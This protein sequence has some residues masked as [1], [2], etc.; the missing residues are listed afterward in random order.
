MKRVSVGVIGCG[1]IAQMM[2][3]PHL[4][5]LTQLFEVNAVCDLNAPLAEAVAKRFEVPRWT[6]DYRTLLA[7]PIEAFL[8]LTSGSHA[9]ITL[10][11][12]RAGKHVFVEKPL[13]YTAS[14]GEALLRA[15][16]LPEQVM[17]GY[18]K[19]FDPSY[20]KAQQL[21]RN[22]GRAPLRAVDVLVLHPEES[23]YQEHHHL[24]ATPAAEVNDAQARAAEQR[25]RVQETVGEATDLVLD[26]FCN[27][28][29]G[30]MVHDVNAVRH[31]VGI[32][33]SVLSCHID[34]R[35][36]SVAV[37]VEFEGGVLG[38]FGWFFLPDLRHY[39]ERIGV[40]ADAS[41]V[42]LEFPSPY[43]ES[44]PTELTLEQMAGGTY[45]TTRYVVSYEEAFREEL[46]ALHRMVTTGE[47]PDTS[48]ED[49][50]SDL[51]VLASMARCAATG[52][53]QRI[54]DGAWP[55]PVQDQT[56]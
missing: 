56:S 49:A 53:P 22:L 43:L 44:V 40:L 15:R 6:I 12:L 45:T 29:L 35:G 47:R 28:M 13:C 3:L 37:T 18:M 14:E 21:V 32:P 11:L 27:V 23:Y 36:K 1:P 39:V 20:R 52:Q 51:Q 42:W 7:Q 4:K 54:P 5:G 10:D 25:T 26:T 34:A 41:R 38:R 48:L 8:V 16:R 46:L 19:R 31:L 9:A 33:R 55:G 30:S 17:V 24:V 2:H 50:L